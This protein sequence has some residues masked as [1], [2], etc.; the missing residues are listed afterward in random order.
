MSFRA[1]QKG[2]PFE[3]NYAKKGVLL[4]PKAGLPPLIEG[5][6]FANFLYELRKRDPL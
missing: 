2:Y 4:P 3:L 5:S 6:L 1:S